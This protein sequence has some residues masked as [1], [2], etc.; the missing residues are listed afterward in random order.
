MG[1]VP[2]GQLS[3]AAIT[4]ARAQAEALRLREKARGHKRAVASHRRQMK[5]A[6]QRLA[7]FECF[8]EEAGITLVLEEVPSAP[9]STGEIAAIAA[10]VK[11]DLT[12]PTQPHSREAQ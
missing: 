8:C 2:S 11:D 1:D 12:H 7:D 6:M 10:E 3:A 4:P 9:L 5:E